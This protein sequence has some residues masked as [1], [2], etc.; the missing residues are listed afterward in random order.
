MAIASSDRAEAQ[1]HP[2]NGQN[3]ILAPTQPCKQPVPEIGNGEP[4]HMVRSSNSRVDI[5]LSFRA[6]PTTRVPKTARGLCAAGVVDS[7]L[8]RVCLRI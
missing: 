6:L 7:D 8:H 2:V 5:I 3:R 1:H 4:S